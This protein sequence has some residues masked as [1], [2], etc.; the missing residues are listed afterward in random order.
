ML[1]KD[2]LEIL[3]SSELQMCDIQMP[4][5]PIGHENIAI[6]PMGISNLVNLHV[7]RKNIYDYCVA[8]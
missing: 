3:V 6:G 5:S 1:N 4:I 8:Q 2:A 7:C